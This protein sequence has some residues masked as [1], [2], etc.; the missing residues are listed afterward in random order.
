MLAR[1]ASGPGAG[2]E[3]AAPATLLAVAGGALISGRTVLTNEARTMG[4][5]GPGMAGLLLA[6]EPP[7]ASTGGTD[8][9]ATFE[10]ALIEENIPEGRVFPGGIEGL[11]PEGGRAELGGGGVGRDST[12]EATLA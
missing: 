6:E 5:L 3:R 12:A 11:S 1:T 10:G 7:P 9:G 2:P 8:A 4:A